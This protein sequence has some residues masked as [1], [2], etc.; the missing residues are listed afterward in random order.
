[1]NLKRAHLWL[2][3]LAGLLVIDG[4]AISGASARP[5]SA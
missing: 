3:S 5:W 4:A 1:M 2:V